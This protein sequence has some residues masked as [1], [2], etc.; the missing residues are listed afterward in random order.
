MRVRQVF[1]A[2]LLVLL[3][4]CTG[5]PAES[6]PSTSA[7]S[8]S[9]TGTPSSQASEPPL[10][11]PASFDPSNPVVPGFVPRAVL[12]LDEEHGILGGRI[13]CPK[14]CEGNNDGILAVTNDAGAT[15]RLTERID[16]PITHLTAVPITGTVWATA[17]RCDYFFDDCGRRLLR[18][19]DGG[20]SWVN[21]GWWVVNPSFA[22]PSLGFGAGAPLRD[23]LHPQLS[24]VTIDGGKTWRMQQGPCGGYQDMTVGFSFPTP[25]LGWA[26]CASS[27]PGAGFFQFKAVYRTTDGG[28][29]WTPTASFSPGHTFGRGLWANGGALGIHM[30]ADGTGYFWAGGGYA[31]LVHTSDGGHTWRTVWK[32]GGG[33]G[34]ELTDISWL[35]PT[36]A[37]A[38]RWNS[39][40]GWTLARTEDGG[41]RWASL[42]RWPRHE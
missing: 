26:A 16:T 7:A 10:I 36:H 8:T 37:Y 34:K 35:D 20:A 32:D 33:G 13:E 42:T 24:A 17:S 21:R 18:S 40:F 2:L 31:Y 41:R 22:S 9:V 11:D 15:W 38:V 1:A 14:R 30:F 6:V 28:T 23:G 29:T 39:G 19:T 3:T 12:F 27:S 5:A 4:A 25:E